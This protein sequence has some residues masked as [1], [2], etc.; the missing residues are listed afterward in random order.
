MART[1][2]QGV[3]QARATLERLAEIG[4]DLR[5][6]AGR[7]EVE[8]VAAFAKSFDGLLAMLEAKRIEARSA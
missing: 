6:V 8:G 4:V 3:D 7:L 1:I 2:D 5:D